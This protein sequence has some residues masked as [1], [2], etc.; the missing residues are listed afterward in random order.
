MNN[1]SN[2]LKTA[3]LVFQQKT[4]LE[5]GHIAEMCG[6]TSSWLATIEDPSYKW[7]ECDY[8]FAKKLENFYGEI[9]F[10]DSEEPVYILNPKVSN[11]HLY[12]IRI[13][14]ENNNYYKIGITSTGELKSRFPAPNKIKYK[15]LM[16]RW[17]PSKKS[18]RE[19]E[20]NILKTF[21]RY[22][23]VGR[24]LN[25]TSQEIFCCDVLGLDKELMGEI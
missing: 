4:G 25:Q 23:V 21:D 11:W 1:I 6:Y 24:V 20:Q 3:R 18:A 19:V 15:Q 7:Q 10:E 17:Y 8:K 14:H 12:Y 13:E 22:R 2:K 16:F 9:I 5:I